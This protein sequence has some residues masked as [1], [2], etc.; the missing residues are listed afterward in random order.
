MEVFEQGLAEHQKAI[1][2]DGLTISA[3]AI[4]EHNVVA[5]SRIYNNVRLVELGT[6]LQI[7]PQQAEQVAARMISEGRLKARIDQIDGV[8]QYESS[9]G[10]LQQW[11][12]QISGTCLAL[13]R[14]CHAIEISNQR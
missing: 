3:R 12:E 7:S 13:N 6:F 8:L 10:N 1:T 14:V 5:A 2:S 4:I 11:D 9:S